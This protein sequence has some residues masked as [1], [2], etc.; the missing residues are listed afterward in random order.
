[1]RRQ[2]EDVGLR[3]HP[4]L[5]NFEAKPISS[6]LVILTPDLLAFV[7][8]VILLKFMIILLYISILLIFNL[9]LLIC[10]P[11]R[12][13][14]KCPASDYSPYTPIGVDLFICPRKINHIAQHIELPN[15]K[16]NGK[17]PPLLVVNIQVCFGIAVFLLCLLLFLPSNL[18]GVFWWNI[19]LQFHKGKMFPSNFLY[20][21]LL[22]VLCP[23]AVAYLSCCNVPWW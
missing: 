3:F 11:Y 4:Q 21:I 9:K 22:F 23:V 5:L 20:C 12:D 2:I 6:M 10:L 14:R 16:A 8:V 19:A 17:V 13:K 18:C 15:I 1:M 7:L